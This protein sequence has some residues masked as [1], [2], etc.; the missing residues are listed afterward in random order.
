MTDEHIIPRGIGGALVIPSGTCLVCKEAIDPVE[1]SVINNTLGNFR[2]RTGF[3]SRKG[4]VRRGTVTIHVAD[5]IARTSFTPKKIPLSD[6]PRILILP[7][8]PPP[9]MLCGPWTVE[10]L[11]WTRVVNKDF[12]LIAEKHAQHGWLPNAIK[13]KMT[14]FSRM[15]AKIGHAYAVAQLSE[16]QPGALETLKLFLPDLIIRG[17]KKTPRHLVGGNMGLAPPTQDLNEVRLWSGC[18]SKDEYVIATI[19]LFACLGAPDYHVVVGKRPLTAK[20][21]AADPVPLPTL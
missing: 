20:M 4:K 10:P 1:G 16:F 9:T 15:L 18:T 6:Y 14:L 19:R 5:D 7:Q 8:L 21:L 3:A 13:I 2:L 11:A 17:T 12:E